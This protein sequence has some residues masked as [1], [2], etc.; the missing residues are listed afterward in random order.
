MKILPGWLLAV[1]VTIVLGI[2]VLIN[3]GWGPLGPRTCM[4]PDPGPIRLAGM[5]GALDM[6]VGVGGGAAMVMGMGVTAG[7]GGTKCCCCCWGCGAGGGA[8]AMGC[9]GFGVP[10]APLGLTGT[11]FL[12]LGVG[13]GPVPFSSPLLT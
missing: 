6:W 4:G 2:E 1:P 12:G 9:T 10:R 8:G 3:I 13:G 5:G 7:G 11:I